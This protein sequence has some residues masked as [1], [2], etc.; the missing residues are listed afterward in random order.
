MWKFMKRSACQTNRSCKNENAI[1][2]RTDCS[3]YN[4]G[5]EAMTTKKRGEREKVIFLNWVNQLI[6]TEDRARMF[7]YTDESKSHGAELSAYRAVA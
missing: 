1:Q 3:T 7:I 4:V 6:V 2:K 5:P